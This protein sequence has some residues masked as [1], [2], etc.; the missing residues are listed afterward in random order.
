MVIGIIL[1]LG[2][3][4]YFAYRGYSVIF[5]VPIFALLAALTAGMNV[6][7]TY[8]ELFMVKMVGYIKNFFPIFML[9]A[10]FG[11]IMEDSGAP[12]RWPIL[13]SRGSARNG[14][15]WPPCYPAPS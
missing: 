2:L 11:K 14:L 1:S 4:I 15:L 12:V 7:P 6:L 5:M 3:L 13:S 10:V 8:T 9:G